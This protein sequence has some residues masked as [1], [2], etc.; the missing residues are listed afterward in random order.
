VLTKRH[1]KYNRLTKVITVAVST[2]NLSF[3]NCGLLGNSP[4]FT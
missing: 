4:L 3:N 2:D 1:E